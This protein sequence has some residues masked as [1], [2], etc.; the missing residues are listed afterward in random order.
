MQKLRERRKARDRPT[1]TQ[2]GIHHSRSI[3]A[4][5]AASYWTVLLQK[6]HTVRG[7]DDVR[8]ESKTSY[9]KILFHEGDRGSQDERGEE[10]QMD[11]VSRTV[12]LPDK[13]KCLL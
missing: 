5:I 6:E 9:Q 10:V 12:Q 11:G 1:N 8:W 4:I 2:A 13:R 7:L 3:T